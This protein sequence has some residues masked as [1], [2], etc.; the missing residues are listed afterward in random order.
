MK[1]DVSNERGFVH[2]LIGDGVPLFELTAAALFVC[3]AFAAGALTLAACALLTRPWDHG[4]PATSPVASS[5]AVITAAVA[6]YRANRLPGTAVPAW[7]APALSR[8]RLLSS[9]LT[10]VISIINDIR[11]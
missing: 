10:D 4:R 6:S 3:G 8:L 9:T 11:G 5:P 2:E 7:P 1:Q